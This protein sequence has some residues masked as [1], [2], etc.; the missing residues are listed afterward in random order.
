VDKPTSHK[1]VQPHLKVQPPVAV[2]EL[3]RDHN[4]QVR[5]TE[6]ARALALLRKPRAVPIKYTFL[7]AFKSHN[8]NRLAWQ[9][10]RCDELHKAHG[11]VSSA[12][13]A[14]IGAAAWHHAAAAYANELGSRTG[15]LDDFNMA[16]R[17]SNA[18]RQ[19]VQAAWDLGVKEAEAR[20]R[21]DPTAGNSMGDLLTAITNEPEAELLDPDG[22]PPPEDS[23]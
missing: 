16:T 4:G 10:Q 17:F 20:R 18:A 15:N 19:N 9:Q 1:G 22:D 12:V 8:D 11:H 3:P 2:P 21:N 7:D 13:A 6:A 5:N 14:L 23:E